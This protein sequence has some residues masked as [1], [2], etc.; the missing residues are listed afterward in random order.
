MDIVARESRL[1]LYTLSK[2]FCS[3]HLANPR[4]TGLASNPGNVHMF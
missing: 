1:N 4:V 3:S 2:G